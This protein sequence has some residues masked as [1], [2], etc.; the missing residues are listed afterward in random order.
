M[1]QRKTY[2]CPHP[3]N[4]SWL[5]CSEDFRSCS[6]MGLFKLAIGPQ[7]MLLLDAGTTACDAED[8]I[9]IFPAQQA[10]CRKEKKN[11]AYDREICKHL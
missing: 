7:L 1:T 11:M 6:K 3:P 10:A 2:S 4:T 9:K 5:L 8:I